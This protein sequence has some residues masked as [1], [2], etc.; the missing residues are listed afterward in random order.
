L[1]ISGDNALNAKPKS[2]NPCEELLDIAQ[3][4][5]ASVFVAEFVSKATAA[6]EVA[7]II[8]RLPPGMA[9]RSAWKVVR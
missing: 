7:G 2:L 9:R 8:G 4:H 3:G 6:V 5:D 1:P